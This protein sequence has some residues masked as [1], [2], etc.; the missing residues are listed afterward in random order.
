MAILLRIGG[1]EKVQASSQ[2]GKVSFLIGVKP[3]GELLG[4]PPVKKSNRL[5]TKVLNG[6]SSK[7]NHHCVTVRLAGLA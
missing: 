4:V 3:K 5:E 6:V 2:K 7:A 1:C